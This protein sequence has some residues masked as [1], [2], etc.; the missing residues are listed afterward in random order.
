[1]SQ[2]IDADRIQSMTQETVMATKP[3]SDIVDVVDPGMINKATVCL[4]FEANE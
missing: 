2:Q 3:G 1:M 4:D